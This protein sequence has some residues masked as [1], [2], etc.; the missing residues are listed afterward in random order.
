M[1]HYG[2]GGFDPDQIPG[3]SLHEAQR[4]QCAKK[5]GRHYRQRTHKHKKSKDV[6]FHRT[7]ANEAFAEIYFRKHRVIS[8]RQQ[9]LNVKGD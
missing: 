1:R 3:S 7:V 5:E 6:Q 8:G 9:I 2:F 4:E